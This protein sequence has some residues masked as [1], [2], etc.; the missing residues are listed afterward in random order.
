MALFRRHTRT[1]HGESR[2]KARLFYQQILEEM[3]RERQQ[4]NEHCV[5]PHIISEDE[6]RSDAARKQQ[7]CA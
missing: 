7:K 6:K 3:D 4:L 1:R 5:A 2:R